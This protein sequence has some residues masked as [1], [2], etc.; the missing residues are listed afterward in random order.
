MRRW[1]ISSSHGAAWFPVFL[2]QSSHWTVC[3]FTV[4]GQ[5]EAMFPGP[6]LDCCEGFILRKL[7]RLRGSTLV[8]SRLWSCR[9]HLYSSRMSHVFFPAMLLDSSVMDSPTCCQQLLR[10]QLR[11]LELGCTSDNRMLHQKQTLVPCTEG[12]ANWFF[13]LIWYWVL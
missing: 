7:K 2:E 4:R 9:D 3:F 6:S 1:A 5:G 10:F 8:A 11:R 13:I 12:A